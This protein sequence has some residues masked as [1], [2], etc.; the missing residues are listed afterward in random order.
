M[1][2]RLCVNLTQRQNGCNLIFVYP[3]LIKS[4]SVHANALAHYACLLAKLYW[5]VHNKLIHP[6]VKSALSAGTYLYLL[7]K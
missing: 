5:L 6:H 1:A 7:F 2:N 3:V 4:A